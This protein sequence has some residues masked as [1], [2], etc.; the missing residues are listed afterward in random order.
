[1]SVGKPAFLS[2]LTSLPE[3]GGQA[4]YYFDSFDADS[5]AETIK[6]GLADFD[7][8]PHRPDELRAH[9]SRYSWMR[10]ATEYWSLYDEV[11]RSPRR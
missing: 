3:I 5:M 8:H 1:M 6:H 11:F 7:S 2:K 10:A 9:A 4:A